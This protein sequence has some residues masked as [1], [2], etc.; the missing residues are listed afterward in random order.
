MNDRVYLYVADAVLIA[1]VCIVLFVVIGLV[2]IVAG[3][4]RRWR[5]VN[6]WWFRMAH[7]AVIAVVVAETWFDVACPLTTLEMWLRSRGQ[8][9]TYSQGFIEHWLQRLLFY[10]AP[11]WVFTLSYTVFALL[12]IAVW[13]R[14]PPTRARKTQ[15][16]GNALT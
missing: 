9:A 4:L 12:V 10:D 5:W 11:S 1:H 6:A 14:Y 15:R 3:N 2:L 16:S 13:L 8:V 7:L